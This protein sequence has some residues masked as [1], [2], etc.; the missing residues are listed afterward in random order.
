[1]EKVKDRIV[2]RGEPV[3]GD[4]WLYDIFYSGSDDGALELDIAL[5]FADP[6]G[7]FPGCRAIMQGALMTD[8]SPRQL[9]SQIGLPPDTPDTS[10]YVDAGCS[11]DVYVADDP[12]EGCSCGGEDPDSGGCEGDTGGSEGCEG[13][14]GGSE[15]CEGD[16]GGCSD[17][18]GSGACAD[19]GSQDCST[20]G[21]L[22]RFF[23]HLPQSLALL[24]VFLTRRRSRTRAEQSEPRG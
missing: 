10:A 2:F 3:T 22:G 5:V 20:A 18:S 9:R 14:T 6:D 19:S 8:P 15:G 23:R 21:R 13:D 12:G 1:M 7:T 16:T 24:V 11:G 4:I 17:A